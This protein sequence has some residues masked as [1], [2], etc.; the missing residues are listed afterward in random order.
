MR[1][2]TPHFNYANSASNTEHGMS[3]TRK[4]VAELISL[5]EDYEEVKLEKITD[6][7]TLVVDGQGVY[8]NDARDFQQSPGYFC[9]VLGIYDPQ[10]PYGKR[11]SP[12]MIEMSKAVNIGTLKK[13]TKVS[14]RAERIVKID[15]KESVLTAASTAVV[16]NFEDAKSD[17][18]SPLFKHFSTD[19]FNVSFYKYKNEVYI[20]SARLTNLGEKC[21]AF[22]E[23]NVAMDSKSVECIDYLNERLA[24][25]AKRLA[26]YDYNKRNSSAPEN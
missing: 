17:A 6:T 15:G 10:R 9:Y 23:A 25:R 12:Q 16:Q 21:I 11:I 3:E 4:R 19:H 7:F 24:K 2:A 18:N 1:I 13:D 20:T 22:S 8:A 26:D 5:L 14:L